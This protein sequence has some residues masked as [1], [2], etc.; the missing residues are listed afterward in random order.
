VP[1]VEG[2]LVERVLQHLAEIGRG[3]CSIS[4]EG[5]AAERDPVVQEILAGLLMLHEDLQHAQRRQSA[6]LEDLRDAIRARDEF[7]SVASHE[8]RTPIT[9]LTLQVDG[10]LRMLQGQVTGALSD[11]LSRRLD[12]TRRQVD[13]LAGLVA[14]LID[15]SRIT[16]GRV[17]LSRQLADL[18]D[19]VR[20]VTER[21]G[22]EAQRSGSSL[23]F[24]R[25]PP[26]WGNFDVARV[27]Q[28]LTNLLTN[29]IRYGRGRPITAGVAG[30]RD[31]ASFW[32]EDQGIGIEPE[33]QVRIFQRYERAAPSTNYA[34]LGLGLWIS[35]Q[36]VEAMG[37][38]IAV[39][40]E[41][42]VGS[43]FTVEIPRAG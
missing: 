23:R 17:Q 43:T 7:L 3:A 21:F 19:V 12:V 37:G 9:T 4:D 41:A 32:V 26:I 5:I 27:D 38:T 1:S 14:T 8:L 15:V 10:L 11:K 16:S 28:V 34:G 29:A 31:R 35:R 22:E 36:L 30:D 20:S 25:H 33:H 6:L 40:S 39:R 2:N 18:V 13:R 24:E 42:G